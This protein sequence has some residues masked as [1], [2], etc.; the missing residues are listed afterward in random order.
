MNRIMIDADFY[1]VNRLERF[2]LENEKEL[3]IEDE[4]YATRVFYNHQEAYKY[5]QFYRTEIKACFVKIALREELKILKKMQ[6]VKSKAFFL[7]YTDNPDLKEEL[8]SLTTAPLWTQMNVPSNHDSEVKKMIEKVLRYSFINE[9]NIVEINGYPISVD[10]L[11]YIETDK[12]HRNYL[13]AV[14][15]DNEC[16]IRGTI[17]DVKKKIPDLLSLGRGLLVVSKKI[18]RIENDGLTLCFEQSLKK[19]KAPTICKKELKK[20]S[21]Q[22]K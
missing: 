13:R 21:K 17:S 15:K 16:L 20:Y 22:I 8:L 6:K 14:T 9:L 18:H 5:L 2:V 4:I 11:L 7:I 1:A 12:N 19:V 10:S 3:E